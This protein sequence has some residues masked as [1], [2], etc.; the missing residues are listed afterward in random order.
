MKIA[1]DGTIVYPKENQNREQ[2]RVI[3]G[4]KPETIEW[5]TAIKTILKFQKFIQELKF[6][7]L[8]M[9]EAILGYGSLVKIV[10]EMIEEELDKG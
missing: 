3:L 1:T 4:D 2:E 9:L 7:E 6:H 5:A 8:E 10:Q